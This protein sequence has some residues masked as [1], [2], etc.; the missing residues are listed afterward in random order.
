MTIEVSQGL[1]NRKITL[2]GIVQQFSRLLD[3]S[4]LIVRARQIYRST[5]ETQ[6]RFPDQ[7]DGQTRSGG[8]SDTR[9]RG[10]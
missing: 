2:I 5:E 1:R 10:R 8:G 7:P 9:Y 6:F 4:H 3:P